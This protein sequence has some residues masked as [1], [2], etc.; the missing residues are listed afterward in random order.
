MLHFVAEHWPWL[1]L[2]YLVGVGWTLALCRAA[3]RA[4]EALERAWAERHDSAMRPGRAKRRSRPASAGR[5]R[6]SPAV[7]LP[8]SVRSSRAA[9]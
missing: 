5:T 4:D 2:A 9:R 8:G 6:T 3:K 7:P 1:A